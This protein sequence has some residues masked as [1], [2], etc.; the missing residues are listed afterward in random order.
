MKR[1]VVEYEKIRKKRNHLVI[2]NGKLSAM[3]FKK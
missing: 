2:D 1:K 3:P